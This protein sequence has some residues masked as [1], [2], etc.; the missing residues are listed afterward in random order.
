MSEEMGSTCA[1]GGTCGCGG[2]D[3]QVEEIYL[4]R[5]E[6]IA[7]LEQYLLEL[8]AEIQSVENELVQ[9]RQEA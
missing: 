4:T 5:S 6:Y 9:L 3:H 1:C 7:R 2:H 8:K